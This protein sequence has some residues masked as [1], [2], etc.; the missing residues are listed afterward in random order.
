MAQ[1][2]V[3]I[4]TMSPLAGLHV[5]DSSVL[6]TSP[7]TL[8]AVPNFPPVSG[9]GNRMMWYSDKAAFRAG[10][11]SSLQ[12]DKDSIGTYSF[13]SGLNSKAKGLSATAMGYQ[14]TATGISSTAIG[15]EASAIGDFATA[16]GYRTIA[17]GQAS[18][19]LGNAT[20][21]NGYS[22]TAMGFQTTAGANFST[23]MGLYNVAKGYSSTVIGLYNDSILTS[24]QPGISPA[25]PLFIIGNGDDPSSRSNAMTVLKN[26]SVG[27]GTSDPDA[28]ALLHVSTDPG[29]TKGFL[30]T[31]NYN[32]PSSVPDLGEGTRMMFFPGKASFR[33]GYAIGT[34]W[35][36]ANVGYISSALGYGTIASE[37]YTTAFGAHTIAS[38]IISTA[39]GY[40]T[41][42]TTYYATAMGWLSNAN[43]YTS[44]AMGHATYAKAVSSTAIGSFNDSTDNPLYYSGVGSDRIFQIGNGSDFNLRK[45]AMT[46][47]RNG[48]TGIGALLPLARLHVADSSVLFSAIN[49]IPVTPGPP[50][51]EGIGRR[52]MWYPNKAAFRVGYVSSQDWDK[53]SIGNY[54]FASGYNS[55]A[56]GL[57]ST[58]MGFGNKAEGNYSTA[59]GYGNASSGSTATVFGL[60]NISSGNIST[61]LG[62]GTTSSN[63]VSTAMGYQTIASGYFSTAMGRGTIASATSSISM[64]ENTTASGYA[65]TAMGSYTV[66]SGSQSTAIGVSANST[67]DY[68]IAMGE[69]VTANSWVSTALGR[70]NDPIV[71]SPSSSWILSEPLLI[72]GNGTGAGDKKNALAIAKNGSIFIDPSN[73]NDG[74]LNGNSLLFGSYNGT[75]EGIVSKRTASGN[76]YGLDFFTSGSAKLSISNAGN[77]GIGN[78]TPGFP[79]NFSSALGDKISL[80]GNSANNYG[81]GIQ[82]NLLQIHASEVG[83][84]IAFGYGSSSSLTETMRIKGNGNVGIGKNNPGNKL[85]VVV[86]ASGATPF[87]PGFT[88]M[89]V[90]GNSHTYINLLSPEANETAILFGKPSSAASGGIMYNNASNLNGFQFRVGGNNPKLDLFSN[91]NATLQG[92]LTQSSDAR[93]KKNIT[94]L[95]NSLQKITRLNG[96]NYS[97]KDESADQNLQTGVLA[98]EVQKLFPELVKEDEKGMLSV[99]YSGLIPVVVESIKEQQNFIEKQQEQISNQQKQI[100]ELKK[101][102]EKLLKQ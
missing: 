39:M 95:Q 27:I 8:P 79:L 54:S 73:K 89:V 33:A 9:M 86:G 25:T 40:A 52:M 94:P 20:I 71:A 67:A 35:N 10:R 26:G 23:A 64:G 96:Y 36:N 74:T 3:G 99:N 102:V 57:N 82:N 24:N 63:D 53:D 60:N 83:E 66:A 72:V 6:F 4:N 56:K 70:H 16:M 69:S 29:N 17:D 84:D 97:W 75:G 80:F 44:T 81:F 37:S 101:M 100:D 55:R 42:A 76:Q 48:N 87:S 43:G 46:V 31:G 88:P 93:L 22:A 68:S 28:S 51:A 78:S 11:V 34:S 45:N 58:A 65:S 14:G 62:N 18:T 47:L 85:H 21:A 98:Q 1:K 77:V 49:D 2:R 91:G 13:A 90:E 30:V 92:I 38:G 41:K 12:W 59:L 50:P 15:N 7:A 32:A 19:A 5:A 61:A